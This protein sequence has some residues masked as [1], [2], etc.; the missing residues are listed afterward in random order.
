MYLKYQHQFQPAWC[1]NLSSAL[2]KDNCLLFW[3]EN[4]SHTIYAKRQ[5]SLVYKI[6][7][8]LSH[9]NNNIFKFRDF[10]MVFMLLFF[11][12]LVYISDYSKQLGNASETTYKHA[13]LF[14]CYRTLFHFI[15]NTTKRLN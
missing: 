4:L 3:C 15:T 13:V 11:L 1:E 9:H 5:L 6:A 10:Y 14:N 7:Q 2:R 12:Y 8:K